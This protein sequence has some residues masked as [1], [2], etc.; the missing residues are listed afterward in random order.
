MFIAR[1][2]IRRQR[3][4]L[5]RLIKGRSGAAAFEWVLLLVAIAIPAYYIIV[6]ALDLLTAHYE[7]ITTLNGLPFP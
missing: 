2:W 1:T 5:R 7:M 6:L 3:M 4:E